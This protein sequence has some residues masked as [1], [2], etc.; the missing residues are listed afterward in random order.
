MGHAGVGAQR[1]A[2]AIVADPEVVLLDEPT[3]GLDEETAR[4]VREA[5]FRLAEGRT[6]FWSTHHLE[7]AM[8]F[9][10][11]LEVEGGGVRIRH[12]APAPDSGGGFRA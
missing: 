10:A 11:V 1:V 12:S 2:Q 8:A 9:D 7:E 3:S 4:S 5:L 6:C